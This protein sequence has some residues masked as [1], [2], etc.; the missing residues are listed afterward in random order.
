MCFFFHNLFFPVIQQDFSIFFRIY[1]I[2]M[3]IFCNCVRAFCFICSYT[4]NVELAALQHFYSYKA[5][6][7]QF[8]TFF[9]MFGFYF[10]KNFH[11][12]VRI[13]QQASQYTRQFNTVCASVGDLYAVS[14]FK[15]V[16]ADDHIQMCCGFFQQCACSGYCQTNCYGFCTAHAG[17][18]FTSD[19][20]QCHFHIHL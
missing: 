4:F 9:H 11:S 6:F 7:Y 8:L 5:S 13:S 12:V 18:H 16:G 10:R 15:D 17:F 19:C 20:F 14:V 3:G 2:V 1:Q